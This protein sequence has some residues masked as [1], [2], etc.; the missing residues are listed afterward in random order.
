MKLRVVAAIAS[1]FAALPAVAHAQAQGWTAYDRPAQNGVISEKD[2]P[3]TMRDGI[4]LYANVDRPDRP[5]RYPVLLTQT[6][7]NK[8]GVVNL[9]GASSNKYFVQRG[10]VLVTVDV[11]GTGSS[12]GVW[13]S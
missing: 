5:G 2:V 8:D 6:P 10:Y 7:Y 1:L 12:Q 11:R 13:D 3:I 4:V 9:A